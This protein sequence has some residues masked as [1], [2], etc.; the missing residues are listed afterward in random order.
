[1]SKTPRDE[2]KGENAFKLEQ[3]G[4]TH[5]TITIKWNEVDDP[6]V[7]CYEIRYRIKPVGKDK[8]AWKIKSTDGLQTEITID[9]LNADCAY[10]FKLVGLYE[11]DNVFSSK[12]I[13]EFR[14]KLSLARCVQEDMKLDQEHQL[15]SGIPIYQFNTQVTNLAEGVRKCDILLNQKQNPEQE[16]EY[17]TVLMVGETG[18]GKSSFID[19]L[20][21][22][23]TGVSLNDEFRFKL[24]SLTEVEQTKRNK[25][26]LSQTESVTWYR[27]P[28]IAG[29]PLNYSFNIIDTPGFGDTSGIEKDKTIVTL[30]RNFFEKYIDSG[31]SKVNA[32]CFVVKSD[33]EKLTVQQ[34]YIFEC[35]SLTF[36]K[37]IRNNICIIATHADRT[38]PRI[39]ETMGKKGLPIEHFCQFDNKQFDECFGI[40]A[41]LAQKI[42]NQNFQ[43]FFALLNILKPCTV[44]TT[45]EMMKK[46]DKLDFTLRHLLQKV[47]ESVVK[48]IACRL[49]YKMEKECALTKND[50][51]NY[52]NYHP[53][54]ELHIKPC[55]A[56]LRAI[57]CK[58]CNQTC[59]YPC[60]IK[61][62]KLIW[63][64]TAMKRTAGTCIVCPRNCPWSFHTTETEY[65]E[66][67]QTIETTT[68]E[69]KLK[70]FN[71]AKEGVEEHYR[72]SNEVFEDVRQILSDI[73]DLIKD[74]RECVKGINDRSTKEGSLLTYLNILLER[75][76]EE[77]A[78]V[79][80]DR[81]YILLKLKDAVENYLS[82]KSFENLKKLLTSNDFINAAMSGQNG[83]EHIAVQI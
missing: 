53:K 17:K 77:L 48:V 3:V 81:Q 74:M 68:S 55:I 58:T 25:K 5:N 61:H 8:N 23:V 22:N 45:V 65:I 64:C 13:S 70:S 71:K 24:I 26:I 47:D 29:T 52:K 44:A 69:D 73:A 14:T 62:K 78:R 35:L 20:I 67:V 6:E 27:I 46:K 50:N 54:T 39:L 49:Q 12:V 16:Q 4:L 21:N 34:K 57:N 19:A 56:N 37:D 10:E 15:P 40:E 63:L 43:K 7:D 11:G 42:C 66:M 9:Q 82:D 33:S 80:G 28:P 72:L 31:F 30:L 1:M 36:G 18:T 75:Q 79:Q 83:T 51:A 32:I 76:T 60:D 2:I 41:D 38:V 59:H